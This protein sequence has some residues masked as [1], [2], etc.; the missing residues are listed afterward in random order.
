MSLY[1]ADLPAPAAPVSG[2][3]YIAKLHKFLTANATRLAPRGPP[4]ASAPSVWQ[5]GYTLLTLGL[6]PSSAPLTAK[7]TLG[8]GKGRPGQAGRTPKPL[9]L[10]LP[11][12]RLL[13]LLL[14]WQSLPQSL[15]HVDRTDTPIEEG[16]IIAARGETGS[17]GRRAEGDVRSVRSWVGSMRSVSGS[18]ANVGGRDGGWFGRKKEISEDELLLA[19]YS[20]F[21]LIPA[22]L[23]HPPNSHEAPIAELVEVG[24]YTPLGGIDVRVPLHVLRN[25]QILELE[26]YDPRALQI[27]SNLGLRSLTVRD[28]QDGDDWIADLLVSGD[29]ESQAKF[30][31]LRHLSLV[32]TSLLAFPPLPLDSLTHLDLSHNLLDSVPASLAALS[33]LRSL[34]LSHNYITSLRGASSCLGNVTSLNLSSNRIDCLVGLDRILGLERVD[35]RDNEIHDALELSR[36]A[37]LLYLREV[38]C[39]PNPFTE[40]PNPAMLSEGLETWRVDLGRRFREEGRDAIVFD[41]TPWSWSEERRIEASVLKR[42]GSADARGAAVHGSGL[43]DSHVPH[44]AEPTSEPRKGHG[45]AATHDHAISRQKSKVIRNRA[46]VSFSPTGEGSRSPE[47]GPSRQRSPQPPPSAFH[48]H[49]SHLH[50]SS[51]ASESPSAKSGKGKK[52]GKRRVIDLDGKHEADEDN[53]MGIGRELKDELVAINEAGQQNGK[54]EEVNQAGEKAPKPV[55]DVAVKV[56]SKKKSRKPKET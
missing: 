50:E 28:V 44:N 37:A 10:R 32:Q 20:M 15:P 23:I 48:S 49:A 54:V 36:L 30:P 21:T 47:P 38:H 9:L 42:S 24:G 26:S 53:G 39:S 4:T 1:Q 51:T 12:D 3:A 16:V 31:S 19:L 7:P 25:L 6:D 35:I 56:V 29:G 45:R 33:N 22:L 11:P 41:G 43:S 2:A 27:P 55:E 13:Y 18:L 46:S 17:S 8:L 14:R 52:K 40:C 34:N 5:Q